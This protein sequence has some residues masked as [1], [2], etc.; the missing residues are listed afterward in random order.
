MRPGLSPRVSPG[1]FG[2]M[3]VPRA[4]RGADLPMPSVPLTWKHRFV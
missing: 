4:E 1:L 2:G 3:H